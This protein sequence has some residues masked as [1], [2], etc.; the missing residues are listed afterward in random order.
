[1]YSHQ[2]EQLARQRTDELRR[3]AGRHHRR[4]SLPSPAGSIRNRA[5]WTLV[6]IGLRLAESRGA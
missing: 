2:I 6:A 4:A 3:S 5:G 1:M